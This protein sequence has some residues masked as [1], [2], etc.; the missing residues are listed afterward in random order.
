[1][2][3]NNINYLIDLEEERMA[4]MIM[5]VEGKLTAMDKDCCIPTT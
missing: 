3:P 5:S 4:I 1:V 2:D